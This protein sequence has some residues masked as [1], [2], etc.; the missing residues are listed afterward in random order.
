MLRPAGVSPF[1]A[2]ELP[3]HSSGRLFLM[4]LTTN[5][6]NPKIVLMY[7]AL[8]PQFVVPSRGS[9]FRQ[10]LVLGIVQIVIAVIVNGAIAL[11]ASTVSHILARYPLAMRLQRWLS[12]TILGVLAI[13]ILLRKHIA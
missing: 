12:G 5:L 3:V 11:S 8:I 13:D 1:Q 9:T 7:S 4:G 10:F 2:H 6:L